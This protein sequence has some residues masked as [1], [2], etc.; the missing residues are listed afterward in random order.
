[1]DY[2]SAGGPVV[3]TI[4]G[5]ANDG[6]VG[7]LDNVSISVENITGGPGDDTLTGSGVANRLLG[8]VIRTRR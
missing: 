1:M 2:S 6:E 8:G 7:E 5:G 4:G 3:V